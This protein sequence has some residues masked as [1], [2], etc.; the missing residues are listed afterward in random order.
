M[1]LNTMEDIL[2]FLEIGECPKHF[3]RVQ[4]HCLVRKTLSYQLIGKHLYHKGKDLVLRRV[5]L[6]K[7]IEKILMSCHDGVCGGHF[8]QEIISKKTLQ[9][10]FVWPSLHQDAQ[11]WCW[12]CKACQQAGDHKLSY[13]P[14]FPIFAYGP[15][16]KWGIDAIEPLPRISSGKQYILTVTDYITK[17]AEAVSVA[18]ITATDVRKFVLDYICSRFETPLEIL[19]DRGL[20]FRANLLDALLKNLSIKHVHSTPYYPQSLWVYR[21]SF[22]VSTQFTPYH[23]VYGQEALLPIEVELGSLR[24]LDK[25]TTTSKE[26]L[27]QRILD[28][29]R[30]ELDREASIDYYIIQAN[31]KREKLNNKVKEKKLEEGMLL[32]RYDSKLDLS[33]SKKFLQRWKGPDVIF[34]KFKNGSYWLQNLSGKIHKYPVNGWRLKEFFQRIPPLDKEGQPTT[35]NLPN[36]SPI[37]VIPFELRNAPSTFQGL[38]KAIPTDEEDEEVSFG[39]FDA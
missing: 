1:F 10:G 11:H 7:K 24:V 21:T 19:S 3:E 38:V 28:L 37:K 31:K 29:Q 4:R 26:K 36:A 16:E 2:Y 12:A 18:C 22:K 23:L 39:C 33:H 32:M 13:G 34:K 6:V 9:A 5:P 15:F 20:G 14:R 25:G 27:E 35:R 30:L 17:W 8:A